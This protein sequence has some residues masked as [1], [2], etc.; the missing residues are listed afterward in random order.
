M[1]KELVTL[2][3]ALSFT[4]DVG[5]N[6]SIKAMH[7]YF[8]IAQ[9]AEEA[10]YDDDLQHD[11]AAKAIEV[12]SHQEEIHR[13]HELMEKLEATRKAV[14][15]MLEEIVAAIPMPDHFKWQK[16]ATTKKVSDMEEFGNVAEGVGI[17]TSEALKYCNSLSIKDAS[18]LMGLSEESFIEQY[19]NL[20]DVKTNKD[21]LKRTH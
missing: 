20:V 2:N 18:K 21:T 1:K 15:E 13:L 6:E 19:G 10:P 16:G 14:K 11:L 9:Q 8:C 12:K 7:E 5:I 4:S 17:K 3:D